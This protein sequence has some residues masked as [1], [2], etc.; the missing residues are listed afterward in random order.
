MNLGLTQALV[1]R[2]ACR[3]LL[4]DC[5]ENIIF[6]ITSVQECWKSLS[7][8]STIWIRLRRKTKAP[9]PT[10]SQDFSVRLSAERSKPLVE[11]AARMAN[12]IWRFGQRER[13]DSRRF[14]FVS[15]SSSR[16]ACTQSEV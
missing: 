11:E 6:L 13:L 1:P 8:A 10:G 14:G 15:E 16:S 3:Y 5:G 12:R 7:K 4:I 2:I 9:L